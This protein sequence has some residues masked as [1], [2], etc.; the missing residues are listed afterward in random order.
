MKDGTSFSFNNLTLI[1]DAS[2]LSFVTMLS[3]H[4]N[5]KSIPCLEPLMAAFANITS[6]GWKVFRLN[7]A[8]RFAQVRTLL[9]T[10]IAA[11][12]MQLLFQVL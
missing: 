9:S 7:V 11:V 12:T 10:E 2:S 8:F 5:G 6:R 4:V 1:K 3:A